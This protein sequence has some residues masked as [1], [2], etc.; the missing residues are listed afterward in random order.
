MGTHGLRGFDR[1][2]LGSVATR[3]A[4]RAPCAVLTVPRPP[5]NAGPR[6]GPFY[7]RV[8]CA[9]ELSE[10]QPIIEC[11]FAVG[12][13]AGAPVTLLHVLEDHPEHEAAS[14]L[15]RMDWPALQASLEEDAARRLADAAARCP[16]EGLKVEQVVGRGRPY[17]EILKRTES[18]ESALVVLGTHGRNP[19][20]RLFLGSTAFQVLRGARCPVLTVRLPHSGKAS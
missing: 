10:S 13:A 20:E 5:E 19:L 16:A 14:R 18:A 9:V 12:R 4:H 2:L 6:T 11:A 15:A 8:V 17:R 3:V 1:W 7:A